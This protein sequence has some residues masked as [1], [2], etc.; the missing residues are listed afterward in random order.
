MSEGKQEEKGALDRVG[1]VFHT[2]TDPM[3]T[4]GETFGNLGHSLVDVMGNA[5][6]PKIDVTG[7]IF[8]TEAKGAVSYRAAARLLDCPI[9]S[10]H[11]VRL[12]ARDITKLE[13]FNEKGAE[14]VTFCWDREDTYES[15]LKGV[16]THAK[17]Q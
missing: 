4:I 2:V 11:A 12:G 8:L 17:K 3:K 9:P 1:N 15:A 14:I 7:K 13:D 16:K 10:V 5:L 6:G